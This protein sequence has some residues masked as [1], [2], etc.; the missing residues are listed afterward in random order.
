MKKIFSFIAAL[1]LLF[2]V[3]AAGADAAD[4]FTDIKGHWAEDTIIKWQDKGIVSGYPDGSFKPDNPVTRAELAKIL[5]TAF[6]LENTNE[7]KLIENPYGDVDTNAWYWRYIQC[8]DIYIPMYALPVAYETNMPY[9]ENGE[10]DKNGFLP[11]TDAIRM[12]TAESLVELKRERD[13]IKPNLPDINTIQEALQKTFKDDDY[14]NLYIMHQTVPFNVRRM[15]ENTWL[16]NELGIIKGDAE[17]YFLPYNRVTRAELLT[18]I[19]RIIT[20]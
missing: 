15:F 3:T 6:D 20:N 1:S 8:A 5:T 4:S 10:H 16:A 9:I 13:N 12:H 11:D 19:D 17:G 2:A 14:E 18:M 7:N